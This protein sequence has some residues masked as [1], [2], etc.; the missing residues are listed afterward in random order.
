[1][2]GSF[3]GERGGVKGGIPPRGRT[4]GKLRFCEDR[5]PQWPGERVFLIKDGRKK[6]GL[7][8][9]LHFTAEGG[10]FL[11]GVLDL[12]DDSTMCQ[13]FCLGGLVAGGCGCFG[14][15]PFW[16]GPGCAGGKKSRGARKVR[17]KKNSVGQKCDGCRKKS[18]TMLLQGTRGV[19]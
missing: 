14:W 12:G 18:K 1:M 2:N 9:G 16:G 19:G 10:G 3:R 8:M 15:N 5:S 11:R 13:R 17:R 6:I 7:T 4:K